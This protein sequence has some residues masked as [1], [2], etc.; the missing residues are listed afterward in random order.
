MRYVDI[1]PIPKFPVFTP[2]QAV[3]YARK[4]A[5]SPDKDYTGLCLHFCAW[6]FGFESSGVR[7]AADFWRSTPASQKRPG[8]RKPP[9]GAIACWTGGSK[10]FGHAA[11][12]V[13]YNGDEPMI[14]T[15]D[16]KR[17]GKIDI[18]PL[19]EVEKAWGSQTY[20]GWAKPYFPFGNEDSRTAP[21]VYDDKDSWGKVYQA[22]LVK[23]QKGSQSVRKLQKRLGLKVTGTYNQATVEKSAKWQQ[24]NGWPEGDGTRWGA[25][26]L[27]KLFGGHYFVILAK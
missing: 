16:I 9:V 27:N 17:T 26:Q 11:P 13:G 7:S 10:G 21:D 5:K 3:D 24:G 19:R 2:K 12:V 23:G 22:K 6:V 18:I 15:N 4:Q 20:V 8:D 14:A 1:N 25:K